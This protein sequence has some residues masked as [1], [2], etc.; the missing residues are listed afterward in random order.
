MEQDTTPTPTTADKPQPIIHT[1]KGDVAHV[2]QSDRL[3]IVSMAVKEAKSRSTREE[4]AIGERH[5]NRF[6]VGG[7]LLLVLGA[8]TLW[9]FGY[10]DTE[11]TGEAPSTIPAGPIRADVSVPLVLA[12]RSDEERSA[13]I[14][15]EVRTARL[16]LGAV[17]RISLDLSTQDFLPSVTWRMPD[18]LPRYLGPT[19]FLGVHA[20]DTNSGFLLFDVVSY[21]SAYAAMLEWEKT[22]LLRDTAK[23]LAP[24]RPA[25]SGSGSG[26]FGDQRIK[27]IREQPVDFGLV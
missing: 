1:M 4:E 7:I 21:E 17:E 15:R 27:L 19:L 23:L 9:Y 22:S 12:N 20:F 3:S 13:L 24:G 18:A 14:E 2:V 16:D 10:S 26:T 8:G 11:K 25:S 6:L 5:T